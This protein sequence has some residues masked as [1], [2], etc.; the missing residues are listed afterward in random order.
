M[1]V[2]RQTPHGLGRPHEAKRRYPLRWGCR[3]AFC[4]LETQERN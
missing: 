3:G 2:Q 4:D 1:G